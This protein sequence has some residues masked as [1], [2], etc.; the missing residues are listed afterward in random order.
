MRLS[1]GRGKQLLIGSS[2]KCDVVLD[3]PLAGGRHAYVRGRDDGTI[4]LHDLGSE[5]GTFVDGERVTTRILR[6]GERVTIGGTELEIAPEASD[7]P[8]VAE[9]V[10]E[11]AL[12][13][14][15]GAIPV[16][17]IAGAAG[18]LAVAAV[19]LALAGVFS[20]GGEGPATS[21]KTPEAAGLPGIGSLG[22]VADGVGVAA[23]PQLKAR[24]GVETVMQDDAT[25]LYGKDDAAVAASMKQAKDLGVDRIRLTAGWS[26]LA[27][28]ADADAKPEFDASDPDAYTRNGWN[29]YDPIGHWQV[30]DR[31]VRLAKEAG[32]EVMIDIGFWAPKWA[33]NGDPK[34]ERRTFNI[35]PEL[36]ADFVKSV[37]RRYNG[38][39]VPKY[40]IA[41]P[42]EQQHSSDADLVTS[43]LG[44]LG[45]SKGKQAEPGKV[46][47]PEASG[48]P[49]PKVTLWTVWN[50]PNHLGFIQPQ[51]R[52]QGSNLVPNSGHIYRSLVHAAFPAIKGIQ[53]EAKILV[54]ATSSTGPR[55]VRSETDG[56]PPLAFIRAMACVD[57]KLKP[58]TS[59]PCADFKPIPG[60]GYSHHPYSLLHTPDYSDKRNPDNA[61]IGDLGRLS[62]LLNRLA[63]MR[64]IDPKVRELYLTEFGYESNPPDPI[65]PFSPQEQ[66]RFINWSEY[67]AWKNPQVKMFP[68]FLLK[69]MGTVSAE[70]AAR[71]KREYGDWQ[72]GLYFV[73]GSPKPAA[74]TFPL[75]LHVDCTT[76]GKKKKSSKLLVIW[77]HLRPGDGQR[78]VTLEQ[79]KASFKPAAT[80][81]TL[82][83][84]VV[85]AA[86]VTPF[87]TDANG[88]FLRF[89]PYKKGV[90][91][92]VRADG[93]ATGL[94]VPPDTCTGVSKQKKLVKAGRHEF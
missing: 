86:S 43:V 66:A 33:T 46:S 88:Y 2:E 85:R 4:E 94:A 1:I 82:A 75:A 23:V 27:P 49:L 52:R 73:D 29:K 74:S 11:P 22:E 39:Y 71:G 84:G 63:A 93:G 48:P 41:P 76:M 89:A 62:K 25:F 83:K 77:G 59:G 35:N 32:L 55:T 70:A 47:K 90:Q 30:L 53:P 42:P 5:S 13:G 14:E 72:S 91:Y 37:V 68:Q 38:D 12:A 15:R 50:E 54:G 19:G 67:L 9:A 65:K 31:A 16:R 56:T 6:G 40:G 92:R 26:I 24:A 17:T 28:E 51:W 81:A 45:G 34:T 60:D 44:G 7:P 69:D 20:G 80:A 64:R 3:D 61:G 78:Q 21:F 57:K 58:I 79:G 87:T 8:V 36:Y 18:A 10:A